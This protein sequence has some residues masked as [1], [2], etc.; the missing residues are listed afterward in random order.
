MSISY[1]K[2][3]ELYCANTNRELHTDPVHGIYFNDRNTNKRIYRHTPP[4][5][6]DNDWYA[7]IYTNADEAKVLWEVA[8]NEI[9]PTEAEISSNGGYSLLSSYSFMDTDVPTVSVP[10]SPPVLVL[11]KPEAFPLVIAS[12]NGT[13]FMDEHT[14]HAPKHQ[15]EPAFQAIVVMN[16]SIR[17]NDIDIVTNRTT[18]LLLLRFVKGVSF[19]AFHLDLDFENNTLFIGRKVL[20]AKG[21]SKP[22]S[23][24]R[25]FEAAL[26]KNEIEG[27]T[28]HHRMLKYM[29]G[30]L[31]IV[32]RHEADAYEPNIG[33]LQDP[34]APFG[35][36]PGPIL[37]D[38]KFEAIQ[39]R[40]PCATKIIAQGKLV[41][42]HQIVELKS[43]DS[44]QPKDQMWLGRTPTC[45][46][47][48][49][50]KA[51]FD[52]IYKD[53]SVKVKSIH[54]KGDGSFEEWETRNQESLQK[55]VALLQILRQRVWEGTEEH[56]AI[57]IAKNR[58][59]LKVFAT[60]ERIGALPREIVERFWD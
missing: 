15:Y 52:G 50:H 46:L 27:T 49:K 30:P 44:A 18:I 51:D 14:E 32:V 6:R 35:T 36:Y 42:Q 54:Q 24:G 57:L 59:D 25:N 7:W 48:G 38:T 3:T 10:G 34:D 40:S 31:N 41:P 33:T 55:L 58:N 45:C 9:E 28:S 17:F 13:F 39:H 22:G 26:T 1:A 19:Q 37:G 53:T 56:S 21:H 8:S 4:S 20:H 12:D 11:P 5:P 2:F 23:Y 16:P 60:K 43:N 29:L 47:G